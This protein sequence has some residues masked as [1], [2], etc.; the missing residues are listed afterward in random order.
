M[1]QVYSYHNLNKYDT[2]NDFCSK[3][4]NLPIEFKKEIQSHVNNCESLK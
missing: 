2:I 1:Y 4:I 3:K